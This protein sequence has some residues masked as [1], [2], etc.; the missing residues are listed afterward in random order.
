M[1]VPNP[2]S[3]RFFAWRKRRALSWR[4]GPLQ[5]S[6][7]CRAAQC[8]SKTSSDSKPHHPWSALQ[9]VQ[10]RGLWG[11]RKQRT[12]TSGEEEKK[13]DISEKKKKKRKEKKRKE[14][15]RK[16][17]KRKEPH[18]KKLHF[19]YYNHI[20][21]MEEAKFVQEVQRR[22]R[23]RGIEKKKRKKRKKPACH[24]KFVPASPH[25]PISNF[26]HAK[27]RISQ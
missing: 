4:I 16:E 15:K 11:Q 8:N 22:K 14:K 13:H 9:G 7:G 26:S 12:K 18:L 1:R 27:Q 2:G 24:Q 17:K 25:L 3:P 21:I 10:D 5:Q 20:T 6:L 23:A 19:C